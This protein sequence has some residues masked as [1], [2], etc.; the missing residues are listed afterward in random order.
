MYSIETYG[1]EI[2]CE[3]L[4]LYLYGKTGSRKSSF[5]GAVVIDLIKNKK[6]SG[7]IWHP[8]LSLVQMVKSA[9]LPASRQTPYEILK[10][11]NNNRKILVLDDLG[12]ER[13]T[14]WDAD[15]INSFIWQAYDNNQFVIVTS[16]LKP[17]ELYPDPAVTRRLEALKLIEMKGK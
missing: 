7:V 14:D 16:N 11:S 5:A 15:I 4:G 17:S 3:G 2:D 1:V 6:Y 12:R 13:E 8:I 10:Q 9:I